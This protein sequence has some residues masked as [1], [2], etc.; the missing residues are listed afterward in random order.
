M[1]YASI[2]DRPRRISLFILAAFFVFAGVMHFVSPRFYLKIMP[3]WLPRHG[4][5]VFWSGVFEVL[6]GLGLVPERTRRP[7]GIGLILLLIAVWPANLQ[8]LMDGIATGKSRSYIALLVLRMPL[9]I[10]LMVWVWWASRV[11]PGRM[12]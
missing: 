5:L 4:E 6:G 12:D 11:T 3:R 2:M 7:A 10:P 9:Q 1:S 8:M